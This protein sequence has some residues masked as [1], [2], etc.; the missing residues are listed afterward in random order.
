MLYIAGNTNIKLSAPVTGDYEGVLFYQDRSSPTDLLHVMEG[1]AN[2]ALTGVLYSPNT[3]VN[4][5]GNSKAAGSS[6]TGIIARTVRFTGTSYLG[7]DPT[8]AGFSIGGIGAGGIS[9]VQ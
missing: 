9:L 5:A 7:Q 1:G 2:M 4:Y 8:A 6:Y 3:G